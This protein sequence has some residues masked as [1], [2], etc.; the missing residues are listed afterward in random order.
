MKIQTED[1]RYV[2]DLNS[3]ALLANDLNELHKYRYEKK[4]QQK[5]AN[6]MKQLQ[7]EVQSIKSDIEFIKQLLISERLNVS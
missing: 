1:Q 4:L 3:K 2:R 6:E 7:Q 5:K